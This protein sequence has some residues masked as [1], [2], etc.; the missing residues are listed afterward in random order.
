MKNKVR[1]NQLIES[2]QSPWQKQHEAAKKD[3]VRAYKSKPLL[4]PPEQWIK[5]YH[6]SYARFKEIVL[7]APILGDTSL[8]NCLERRKTTRSFTKT[9]LSIQE[10]S[11]LLKFSVGTNPHRAEERRYYPSAGARYPI[12]TYFLSFHSELPRG[13]YHYY[14]KDN[15]LEL[16]WENDYIDINKYFNTS[17]F[18]WFRDVSGVV[19]L[20]AVFQRTV[21]KYK[22]RG[23]NFIFIDAG[24]IGQNIVLSAEALS[25]KACPFASFYEDALNTLIDIDGKTEAVI[26]TIGIGT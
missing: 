9:P 14:A 6:K 3:S 15:T 19:V 11:T 2:R 1:L 25:L 20:S 4:N 22:N 23:Y 17:L 18:P 26:Y 5:I 24:H 12:E 7:P 16:L 10:I 13:I 21:C 8:S